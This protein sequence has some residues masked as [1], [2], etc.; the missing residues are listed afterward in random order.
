L[1]YAKY[2][3]VRKL[4]SDTIY[5]KPEEDIIKEHDSRKTEPHL[6]FLGMDETRAQDGLAWKIY[7]GA[8]YFALDVSGKG[9]EEQQANAK[10]VVD[11]FEAQGL[12]FLQGRV[13]MTLSADEGGQVTTKMTIWESADALL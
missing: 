12:S 10:E 9:S 11:G 4:V 5:D 3:E 8:P 2:D 1:Y 13:A 6:I 7:S